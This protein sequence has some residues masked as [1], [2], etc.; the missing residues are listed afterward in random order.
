M[1]KPSELKL[2]RESGCCAWCGCTGDLEWDEEQ[3]RWHCKNLDYCY[4]DI[5][6]HRKDYKYVNGEYVLRDKN[7]RSKKN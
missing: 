3:L 5:W 2:L 1:M 6:G 4:D 7:E